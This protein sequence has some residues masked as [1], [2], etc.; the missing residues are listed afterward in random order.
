[1][2]ARYTDRVDVLFDTKANYTSAGRTKNA[3][4]VLGVCDGVTIRV[5]GYVDIAHIPKT[6]EA[7][8]ALVT[9]NDNSL[10]LK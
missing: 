7:L 4:K 9:G 10:A 5:V 1:M 2:N 8:A 3:A 6:Q